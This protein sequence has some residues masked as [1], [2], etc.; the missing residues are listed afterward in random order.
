[1][2]HQKGSV[3]RWIGVSIG[4]AGLA[5]PSALL[6]ANAADQLYERTLMTAADGR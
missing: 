5:M 4:M 1:M 6:A 2:T 3:A